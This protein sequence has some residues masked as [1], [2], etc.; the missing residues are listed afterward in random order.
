MK[1]TVNIFGI[2]AIVLVIGVFY[3]L[4]GIKYRKERDNASV[5]L[6][7]AQQTLNSYQINVAALERSVT[8][9]QVII[10]SNDKYI[11]DLIQEKERLKALGIKNVN[12]IGEL[13]SR[14]EV[15]NKKLSVL[16][17]TINITDTLNILDANCLPIPITFVHRD[18]YSWADVSITRENQHISFGLNNVDFNF[19][20]GDRGN[21]FKERPTV[22]TVD[23]P[24]PY[25]NV[26]EIKAIVV[27]E[28]KKIW[29]RKL[30]WFGAGFVIASFI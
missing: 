25:I 21:F 16:P 2:L 5:A 15:L 14:I 29:D 22:I 1:I 24:N 12:V 26:G 23:T 17:D 28:P 9:Q 4:G 10:V 30:I 19:V 18:K 7:Q 6:Y 11:K 20:I 8:E 13:N 27:K 3:Y